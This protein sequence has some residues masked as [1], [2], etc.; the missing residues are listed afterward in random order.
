MVVVHRLTSL[1]PHAS[2]RTVCHSSITPHDSNWPPPLCTQL[3]DQFVHPAELKA[4][5]GS[6]E[7]AINSSDVPVHRS[8]FA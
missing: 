2:H 4:A 3:V 5:L 7:D 8:L 1:I 6:M